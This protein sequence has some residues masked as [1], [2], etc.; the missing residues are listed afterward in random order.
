MYDSVVS[1]D[2]GYRE[3]RDDEVNILTGCGVSLGSLA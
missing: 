1:R 3:N 2:V